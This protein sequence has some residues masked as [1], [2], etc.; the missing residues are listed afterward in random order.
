MGR[1]EALWE[2]L[3]AYDSARSRN[4]APTGTEPALQGLLNW[5]P[6]DPA[7]PPLPAYSATPE[8]L[9]SVHCRLCLA[10]C[11]SVPP[12]VQDPPQTAHGPDL[13]EQGEGQVP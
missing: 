4:E 2:E 3:A 11:S 6:A 1:D 10:D 7:A 13:P 12:A 5:L 9:S 8:A